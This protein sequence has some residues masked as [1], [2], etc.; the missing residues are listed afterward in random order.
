MALSTILEAIE[1]IKAG[2]FIV[3]VDDENREN[4]G[5][6]AMAAEKVTPDAI[7]LMA[8]EARGL[9][10]LPIIGERLDELKI[11]PMVQENTAQFSTAFT[12]SIEAKHKVTTGISAYDRAATIKAVLDPNTKP[13]D[14]AR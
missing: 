1:D 6:L 13:D 11:P 12:V 9:I 7:N 14:L 8:K 3:V 10:C 5:D 2:K 4:E